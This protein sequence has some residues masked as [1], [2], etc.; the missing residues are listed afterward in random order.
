M[1]FGPHYRMMIEERGEHLTYKSFFSYKHGPWAI[2]Y[3]GGGGA[4]VYTKNKFFGPKWCLDNYSAQRVVE[5]P[6]G[7]V[8]P[9]P[10][11]T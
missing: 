4:I 9:K 5:W 10:S 8:K 11:P 1:H 3:G 6:N 7:Y 2:L